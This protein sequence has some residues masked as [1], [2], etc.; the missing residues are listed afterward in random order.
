MHRGGVTVKHLQRYLDE[1]CFRNNATLLPDHQAVFHS[2]LTGVFSEPLE[3]HRD[4]TAPTGLRST[5]R[6][7]A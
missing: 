5:E 2:L 6:R 4:A 1:F 3:H 7:P